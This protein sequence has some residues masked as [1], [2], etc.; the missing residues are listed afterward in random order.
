MVSFKVA[1]TAEIQ[2]ALFSWVDSPPGIIFQDAQNTN[3]ERHASHASH[4]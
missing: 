1:I 3:N 4:N 2:R